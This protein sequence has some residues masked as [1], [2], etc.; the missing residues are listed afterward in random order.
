MINSKKKGF[1]NVKGFTIVELVIVIAVVAI[2]AAVL[3]PTFSS[4]VRKA[5]IANDTAVAKNMNTALATY[6]DENGNPDSFEEVLIDIEEAGYVLGNLN[7]KAKGN[8]YAW[9][10]K[11]NQIIYIS[12]EGKVIYQNEDFANED[13][14]FVVANGEVALPNWANSENVVDMTKPTSATFLKTVLLEGGNI[15][16]GNNITVTSE[17]ASAKNIVN[18]DALVDFKDYVFNLDL[19]NATGET[20][21]WIGLHVVSGNITITGSENG[22]IITPNN[23]ELYAIYI[24][25]NYTNPDDINVTIK[26]GKF[27]SGGTAVHVKKGTL[28]IEGGFFKS[29]F[30]EIY[31]IN[32]TDANFNDGSAKVIITGGTFVNFNPANNPSEGPE[33]NFVADGYK[34]VSKTQSNGDIWYT[35]VEE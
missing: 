10:E 27:I 18:K 13:L 20:A 7:A 34:V 19:P 11:N 2:L 25:E 15:E 17:A 26:G 24:G 33:T 35:V 16:L 23:E 8:L 12:K 1:T 32:C 28:K 4:L 9:D 5:N 21:N 22:G 30:P 6:S 14:K 3:I 29:T 31:A